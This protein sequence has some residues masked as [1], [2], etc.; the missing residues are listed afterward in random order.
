VVSIEIDD[1]KLVLQGRV[2]LNGI[3]MHMQAGEIYGL[4]GENGA[5]KSSTLT[6]VTGLR[7][8]TSGKV[9][10]LGLDPIRQRAELH[11]AIGVLSEHGGFYGWMSA[12]DSLRW[13]AQLHK[14]FLS[15][16][17]VENLLSRVGLDPGNRKPTRTFSH[18]MKQRLGLARAILHRPRLLILDEPTNGLDPKG[19]KDIHDLLL[20]LNRR[21]GVGIVL[22]THLLDDVERLCNRIGIIHQGETLVEDCMTDLA[23]HH[24][25]LENYYLKQLGTEHAS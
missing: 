25:G 15:Q 1:L 10:V 17:A 9:A 21:E 2:I 4:L 5:G 14:S 19:R 24:G 22:C 18:G 13:Y 23:V 20:D 3:G 16:L 6:V 11:R 12:H 8:A 7:P